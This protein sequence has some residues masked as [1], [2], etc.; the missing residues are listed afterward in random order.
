MKQG[1]LIGTIFLCLL[2]AAEMLQGQTA[3][4]QITGTVTDSTGAVI[5]DVK[6][7]VTN[8]LTGLTRE[9]TTGAGGNYVV[10]LLPVG[11]YSVS[12]EQQ[13]FR[14]ARRSDIQLNVNQIARI[15]LELEVGQVTETV[16]VQATAAAIDTDSSTVG[17]VVTERQVTDLPLN[18]RN[19]LQL[20]FLGA[21][22]VETT[23]EQGSMR[24]GVGNA[25]SINGARPTSNNYMLDGTAN[26]DTALNTPAVVLSVDAIQEFKEQTSTYSAEFGFSAN[27]INLISKS[28]T[29]QLHGTLFWF[30]RNDALDARSYF[31][32]S[33][34]PLRQNQFGFVAGGPVFV[35]KAYDG[36]NKTFWLVNYE[37]ARIRRGIDRFGNVPTPDMLAGRFGT[38]IRDPVTG[39]PFP[40]NVI[41]ENRISRLGNQA[42]RLYFPTPNINLPQGNYRD[43]KSLPNDTN[44]QTLRFDQMLG[45]FGTVFGRVTWGDFTNTGA[46]TIS[47]NGRGE[48]FFR[49]ETRNWQVSHTATLGP[50]IV[51][52]FRLGYVEFTANQFGTPAP[53]SDVDELG[54]TG[55]FTG[56][57]DTQRAYPTI[58][59][60]SGGWSGVGGNVNATQLSNQPMWDVSNGATIIR[61]SHTFA[62]GASYRRW[63]LNRDLAN[64]F[65][66]TYSFSGDFS[67]HPIADMLLGYSQR[68][69]VWQP[70]P[71]SDP[72]AAGN[73]RQTNF[74]YFAPYFQDD[75]K[76]SQR[77]T[78][79]LGLRWDFRTMPYESRDHFGWWNPADPLGGMFVADKQLRELGVIGSGYSMYTPAGRRTPHDAP[80]NVWAPRFGFAFRPF[81]GDKTV[82]RGGYGIFFDSSEEREIDGA[83]DIY[84]YVSRI[85]LVQTVGQEAP[86]QT[87]DEYFTPFADPGPVEPRQNSFLA[88]SQS[89]QKQNPY[90]QQWSLSI[91]RALSSDMTLEFNYLGNKG[92]HLLMRHNFVQALPPDYSIPL[93]DPR[94]TVAAR[95]PYPN[96][97]TFINSLWGGNSSYNSFNVKFEKRTSTMIFSSVY[98][99]AKSLD[100]KSAAAG[101]GATET[102]G[103]QGF[104]NNHNIRLDRAR[105]GF[106][107]DHRLVTSFV[108]QVPFGRGGKYLA[109][110]GRAADM[111]I[112][113]WQINGIVMFQRG[114]PYTVVGRDIGGLLDTFG[115]NRADI[116]ADPELDSGRSIDRWFNTDAFKQP[117]AGYFGTSSRSILRAPGINNWDLG[118]FKNFRFT[119]QLNL[120]FRFESFN[121][122]NHTQ[123]GTPQRNVTSP[124]YGRVTSARPG[125]INQF[126]LKLLW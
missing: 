64:N 59:F 36:R 60:Q 101:I 14:V 108:Y 115:T 25:I 88:V 38:T 92:T 68:T 78:L 4:G 28:G 35:P 100:N 67:G 16:E 85:Q 96:F 75:W 90:M 87:T 13:G 118:L 50:T 122:W 10:P 21:G 110:I 46:G 47:P 20:L 27:Q 6:V 51:N 11:E 56:L 93:G 15:D 89:H 3:T 2:G 81:G 52:Q 80:K 61:G 102:A 94:N 65:L 82:V 30:M 109:N 40:N 43:T 83:S 126:G 91:Q 120:Q 116:I 17:H 9:T 99:W 24:Q 86:L 53:Q 111:L 7:T 48:L 62:F 113:G 63:K 74:Q 23:G 125:R 76:A 44:Q 18:G 34:A 12:A 98:T 33:I 72:N 5:P 37:G 105:S 41:P 95:K 29:N 19:F 69:E 107:V 84:P 73:P 22:A 26:T 117:A 42:R 31:Q 112:G 123:W 124:Q 103:W 97:V 32:Q 39:Q 71:F 1:V 79:N 8:E 57:S 45:R 54:L 119:E 58:G 114:F 55:I 66:G 49:Q 121:A 70:T 104:L 77:L 106:D